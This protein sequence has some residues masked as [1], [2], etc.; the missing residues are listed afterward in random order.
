MNESSQSEH[1]MKA[2]NVLNSNIG[3]KMPEIGPNWPKM[4]KNGQNTAL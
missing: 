3:K 2:D 1:Q 4:A